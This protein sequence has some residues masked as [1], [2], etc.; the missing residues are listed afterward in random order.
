MLLVFSEYPYFVEW[1]LRYRLND[2]L[3]T[4]LGDV[5]GYVR[6]SALN[7]LANIIEIDKVMK[8]IS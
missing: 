8:I 2:A 3:L 4:A 6:A 1:L 5:E 7:V